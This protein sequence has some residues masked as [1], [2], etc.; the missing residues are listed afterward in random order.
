MSLNTCSGCSIGLIFHYFNTSTCG[1]WFWP[2]PV[3]TTEL[4]PKEDGDCGIL[5]SNSF[6]VRVVQRTRKFGKFK[7]YNGSHFSSVHHSFCFSVG[8]PISSFPSFPGKDNGRKRVYVFPKETKNKNKGK[9]R[10]D[11]HNL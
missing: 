1:Y 6:L 11:S 5:K 4:Q 10:R 9:K 2:E 7:N 8:F 3:Y